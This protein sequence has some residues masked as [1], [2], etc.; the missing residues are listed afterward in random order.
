MKLPWNGRQS[1]ESIGRSPA[2]SRALGSILALGVILSASLPARGQT[3]SALYSFQCGPNDAANPLGT[4][5]RDNAGNLY[6]IAEGGG[7]FG[8]GSVFE[9]RA[10][11]SESVLHS[12]A[13]TPDGSDPVGGLVRDTAG[14]LYG[15]TLAGGDFNLGTVFRISPSGKE[16]RL[17][18]FKPLGTDGGSPIGT[19]VRD[20]AGNIY[21]LTNGGG[22][23]GKGTLY[24]VFSTGGD[25]LL[26][27]FGGSR[28][29][30]EYPYSG[31]LDAGGNFFGMT[32][33][34][35][36]YSDGTV[37]EVT[38][39][40]KQ[41]VLHSFAGAPTD[42]NG[43][44]GNL[45]KDSS[46]NLYGATTYGGS[47]SCDLSF[48]P[49]CGMVFQVSSKGAE[50]VVYSFTGAPDGQFPDAGVV[51][52]SAGNLYGT[53]EIG[54]TGPCSATEG[55]GC[56]TIYEITPSGQ[57]SVL[58]SFTDTPD[59]ANPGAPLFLDSSGS[60]YGTT[61][62]GGTYGCGTVFKYTP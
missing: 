53:T 30:A 34:G 39:A 44:V 60:F 2:R 55:P 36:T 49:G 37:F 62:V 42:G 20:S 50:K 26:S 9:L 58:Y 22:R 6:G 31:L 13:G 12:F 56:G 61:L 35:G 29:E 47:G 43:V 41:G 46:G 24:E 5:L 54:G 38:A 14:N 3:Y 16:M 51:R 11:G 19:V 32:S 48:V 8:F 18:D 21:G 15:A 27:Q 40:G 59:G 23:Y 4:L 7:T 25:T 1:L 57:E 28:E 17:H 10:N 33:G 52:D 45:I